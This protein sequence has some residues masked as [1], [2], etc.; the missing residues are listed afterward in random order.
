[1]WL[2]KF[3]AIAKARGYKEVLEPTNPNVDASIEDNDKAYN[4]LILLISDKVTFSIVDEAKST[5]FPTGDAR[6]A[7]LEMKKKYEPKRGYN[8]VKLK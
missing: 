7:W 4:N 3:V 6:I 8:K 1:M 5:I 2:R